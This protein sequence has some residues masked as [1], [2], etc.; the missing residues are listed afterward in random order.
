M[1]S[2]HLI[3]QRVLD[4]LNL[5]LIVV[6][7]LFLLTLTGFVFYATSKIGQFSRQQIEYVQHQNDAQLCAQHDIIVAVR[8][9]GQKLGLPVEDIVVP[10]IEE[11]NCDE[12]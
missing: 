3:P 12:L 4:G 10:N 11:L 9:I 6:V 2:D 8:K 5:L 1:K 7:I